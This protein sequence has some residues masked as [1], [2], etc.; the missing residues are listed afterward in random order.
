MTDVITFPD[1][2]RHHRVRAG[3][4]QRALADLSTVSPRAI[5][6]LESGRANART[7]T[8]HLLADGL[9]LQG[10]VREQF[11][12][13]CLSRRPASRLDDDWCATAPHA[14]DT[15]IGRDAEVHALCGVLEAG[16]RRMITLSGLPGAGKSRVAAE[17]ATTLGARHGWRV[18][19]MGNDMGTL[20]RHGTTFGPLM[21]SLRSLTDAHDGDVAE[22]GQVIGR[23][24][25]V[26]VLDGL[27]E[28]TVPR[29]VQ[30]LLISCPG[31]RIV[32]TSRR[33]WQVPGAHPAVVGPLPTPGLGTTRDPSD[34]AS[35]R[36]LADRLAAAR[37][38][39]TLGPAALA[40]AAEICCRLDGLPLAL[41]TVAERTRVLS[42]AQLAAL[43][44][45]AL[46][47]LATPAGP[48]EAGPTVAALIGGALDRLDGRLHAILR[49]L[50]LRTRATAPEMA[51][52]VR[53]TVDD[54]ADG[55]DQLIG[56]GLVRAW[57]GEL[58][59]ELYV[60]PVVR[61]CLV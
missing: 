11:V 26:L 50:S 54:V 33:P 58:T 23:Q 41:E 31:L 37:P 30:E 12:D 61:A 13:A 10:S 52:A 8:I 35:V 42:L 51:A 28:G 39:F 1:L 56:R 2:L 20:H 22:L 14:A 32:S 6:D 7:Q 18:L 48:G 3:L 45:A 17:L 47:G 15:L 40:V 57:H 16:R 27:A 9:R 34:V 25:A 38:G 24:E 43:P 49:A 21:R 36:L 53:R 4:T 55:L 60:A 59:T 44:A 19:W 29:G 5:R 46:L